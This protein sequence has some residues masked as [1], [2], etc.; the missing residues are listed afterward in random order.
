M[1]LNW[2]Y[3]DILSFPLFF[4]KAISFV[5]CCLLLIPLAGCSVNGVGLPVRQLCFEESN[6]TAFAKVVRTHSKGIHIETRESLGIYFG[7]Y[8]RELIYPAIKQNGESCVSAALLPV[9]SSPKS[10][11]TTVYHDDPV[12]IFTKAYG[13]GLSFSKYEV[14]G[15]IGIS[16]RRVVVVPMES[17]FSMFY[18]NTGG[19]FR[20]PACSIIWS[21]VKRSKQ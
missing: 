10:N 2:Q 3:W 12:Q 4:S 19:V 9:D 15:A 14:T 6:E 17:D 8:D 20:H 13:A 16:H 11:A 18:D 7:V 21:D 5:C 1:N